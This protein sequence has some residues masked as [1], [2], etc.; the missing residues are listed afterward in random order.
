MPEN[1]KR[2]GALGERL[3][4]PAFPS[5]SGYVDVGAVLGAGV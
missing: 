4:S 3:A 2:S 5:S 1:P